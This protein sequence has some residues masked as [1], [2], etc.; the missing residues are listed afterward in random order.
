MS[1]AVTLDPPPRIDEGVRA[2][3]GYI[4][5]IE[6]LRGVAV[7]WVMLF[8]YCVVRSTGA[9]D[10]WIA[11]VDAWQPIALVFRNGYLGVDLFFLITGFLL[12]LPWL[13]NALEGR[14][15]PS[16]TAFYERRA[17]RILPAYYVQLAFLFL[18]F[19]PLLRSWGYLRQDAMYLLFNLGAHVTFLHYATPITSA[20][21]SINGPLWTLALEMQY[22]L[23]LPFIAPFFVRAPLRSALALI[24]VATT[25]RWLSLDDL[26]PLVRAEMHLGSWWNVSEATIRHLLATQLPGYLGHFALGILAGR[27][28][29]A[30][31]ARRWSKVEQAAALGV[32][33]A[34]LCVLYWLYAG[35][36]GHI[37]EMAWLFSIVSMAIAMS[38]LV[39]VDTPVSRA[40][41]ANPALGFVGK[42]SYSAYLYH[43][44][45]LLVINRFWPEVD[46]PGV[47]L[48]YVA[49]ALG[50]AWLSYRCVELPFMRK[51]GA[52][53]PYASPPRA[54]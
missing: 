24:A 39:C 41:L 12:T 37:G 53:R 1:A 33:G 17:R 11:L 10:P 8:H 50:V 40:L 44:P 34:A 13:R 49:T 18:L 25:W 36:S 28:W 22:Y 7:L 19:V 6:G 46:N 2:E 9:K 32:A 51:R 14:P 5:T 43:L 35:G 30:S 54:P 23:V 15:A 31:R 45:I 16:P 42:V 21:L 29:L 27:A 26:D 47:F 20:S 52:A 38:A 4:A 3:V 48:S